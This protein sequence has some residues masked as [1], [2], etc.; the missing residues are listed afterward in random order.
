MVDI[1][2]I[3]RAE[4]VAAAA[5]KLAQSDAAMARILDE[6]GELSLRLRPPGYATLLEIIVGQLV[7]TAAASAICARLDEAGLMDEA[8]V[9]AA[10]VE[11]LRGCGLSRAKA[12]YAQA[13]AQRGMDWDALALLRDKDARAMLT[14]L[15]GVGV[16]TAEVYMLSA[17]GRMDVFPAGDLA[18]QEAWRLAGDEDK[19]LTEQSFRA[20]A[21]KWAPWRAV[22]ARALWSYYR[23]RKQREGLL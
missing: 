22:A 6:V 2:C 1:E 14:A 23:L 20:L 15:P 10:P 16:W 12:G 11:M 7:S 18:L 13:I 8:R 9:A 17:L 4:D 19:R 21:R 3:R 5:E